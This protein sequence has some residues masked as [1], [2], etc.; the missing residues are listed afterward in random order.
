MRKST[1]LG[2]VMLAGWALAALAGSAAV[3]A[4]SPATTEVDTTPVTIAWNSTPDENYV[5]ILMAV[6]AMQEQGY[7]IEA[8]Q[9][10]ETNLV[11]QALTANQVQ[12]GAEGVSTG[13][14]A[15]QEGAPI[16]IISTQNAN[17]V[18]W[19]TT[20]EAADC[21]NLAGQPVGIY[22]LEA[23][24]TVLQNLY[25]ESECP[26][27]TDQVEWVIIQD[28][29][30]RAQA[31][32]EGQIAGTALG[33][34]DA[35]I[36]QRDYPD[37]FNYVYLAQ[38]LP[39]IGDEHFY[40]NTDTLA[41]HPD[42]VR[43]LIREQLL[44]Q[45]SLYENPDSALEQVQKHLPGVE[46]DDVIQQFIEQRIWYAN[47]GLHGPGLENTITGLELPGDAASLADLQPLDDVLAEI[48]M[49]ELTEF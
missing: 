37:Q 26:G 46:T 28:S 16:K 21:A 1:R 6:A 3:S 7:Q 22:S 15:V 20:Q 30:L 12:F 49:S 35:L 10:P 9:L 5:P 36:L 2:P 24:Y 11:I 25:L 14:L 38:A 4:Q 34:P 18:V 39:G 31:L 47:G 40:T 23:G 42:I 33:L 8:R 32:A 45:R 13:A 17:Q 43:A 48:G 27:I 19:V 41:N 44:A 29:P